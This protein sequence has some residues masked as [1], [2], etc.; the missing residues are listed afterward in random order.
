MKHSDI[1]TKFMIE[2]DKANVTSSYPSLTKFEIAQVLNKAY[3]ALIAQKLTGNNPRRVGFEGDPK[4]I[5]DIRPLIVHLKGLTGTQD[6]TVSNMYN[7]D[8]PVDY[9]YHV[10]G[11]LH[12]YKHISSIDNKSHIIQPIGITTHAIAERYKASSTNLPWVKTPVAYLEENQIKVLTD[13]YTT[14]GDMKLDLSYIK[15]P[16]K[17][18]A[19]FGDTTFELND[20]M[21]EELI[22]QAIVNSA[23]IV[24]STRLNTQL[25]TKSL[26]A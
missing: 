19:D 7:Y 10:N 17:F 14:D 12:S 18:T 21:A 1:Y 23:E 2:Y 26:E 5:E 20:S 15:K 11:N 24:E 3:L 6:D 13:S 25:Q 4:A 8:L 9:L 22:N 16:N